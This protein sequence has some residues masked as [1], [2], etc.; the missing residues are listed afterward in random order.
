MN[1]FS[2]MKEL[3]V[4]I[5][6]DLI[7]FFC[8]FGKGFK[9]A[10]NKSFE[11]AK[12]FT[13]DFSE[14]AG[15]TFEDYKKQEEENQR[16]HAEQE[17]EKEKQAAER[18]K[19]K[20]AKQERK[21]RMYA[22]K[23][24]REQKQYEEKTA[25]YK[26]EREKWEK[27]TAEKRAARQ[28]AEAERQE[29]LKKYRAAKE[30]LDN[31]Q[32]WADQYTG[33]RFF[34]AKT[35]IFIVNALD[36]IADVVMILFGIFIVSNFFAGNEHIDNLHFN[37]FCIFKPIIGIDFFAGTDNLTL[38]W[39]FKLLSRIS[40][41]NYTIYLIYLTE[42]S[43]VT[44]VLSPKNRTEP[45]LLVIITILLLVILNL[46][47]CSKQAYSYYAIATLLIAALAMFFFQVSCGNRDRIIKIKVLLSFCLTIVITSILTFFVLL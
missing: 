47:D 43:L 25:R 23:K 33:I 18:E 37:L 12:D 38:L 28:K 21:R 11:K 17:A 36:V 22:E 31:E 29:E 4:C 20:A 32:F 41:L 15:K 24:D 16:K 7:D 19:I 10:L 26:E 14:S 8:K 34:L 27:L 35:L 44:M 9:I 1:F 46:I 45:I 13:E 6:H 40:L 39:L 5:G 42:K 30:E 3:F 2:D